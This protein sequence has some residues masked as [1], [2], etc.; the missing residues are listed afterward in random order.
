MTARASDRGFT[1]LEIT[2]TMAI[3]GVVIAIVYGVF[4]RTLATKEY[5]ETQADEGAL[6]RALVTR[7]TR[8][9][10][11]VAPKVSLAVPTPPRGVTRAVQSALFVCKK[12]TEGGVPLDE[13][14][15]TAFVPRPASLAASATD[16]ATVHYFV[17]PDPAHPQRRG[18]YRETVYGL[19]GEIYDPD[20]PNPAGTVEIADDVVGLQFSFFD[21][22]NWGEEWD[23]TDPRNFGPA[24]QAVQIVLQ[25][26][27]DRG[28]VDVFHTAVDLP[29]VRAALPAQLGASTPRGT[30]TPGR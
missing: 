15:F 17:L 25:V 4:A 8:D 18:L 27:D 10:R 22:K 11:S 13:L 21:G 5:V 23:S 28:A 16:F 24:P 19:S 3:L 9:L 2:I 6:A 20:R 12:H 29:I 14:A 1:L 7:I 30:P 26:R